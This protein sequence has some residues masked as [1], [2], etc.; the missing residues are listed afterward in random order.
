MKISTIYQKKNKIQ[1]LAVWLGL[2]AIL[3]YWIAS[4]ILMPSPLAVLR[5]LLKIATK[6]EALISLLLSSLRILLGLALGIFF[7]LVLGLLAYGLRPARALIDLPINLIKASPLASITIIL[8]TWVSSRSL[9]SSIVGLVVLPNIYIGVVDCLDAI[10]PKL[11]EVKEVFQLG[12]LKSLRYIYLEELRQ[13]LPP[14]LIVSVGLAFKSGVSAEVL[15]LINRSIG[16]YIYHAKIYLD[17][18]QLFAWTLLI[19]FLSK[20]FEY[21]ILKFLRRLD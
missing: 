2:W 13:A 4:P 11:L 10:D 15:A 6:G 5:A 16:D 21:L 9:A 18:A 7:G 20:F 3:S 17:T 8:L 14:A 12:P 19:I 1:A